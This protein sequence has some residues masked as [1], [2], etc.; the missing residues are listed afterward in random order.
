ME[1]GVR[2]NVALR[3]VAVAATV[4]SVK[5]DR[6]YVTFDDGL[7]RA[8]KLRSIKACLTTPKYGIESIDELLKDQPES[9]YFI[10]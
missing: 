2:V 10:I 9:W 3:G 7:Q 1:I 6:V 4:T 8:Y 5:G